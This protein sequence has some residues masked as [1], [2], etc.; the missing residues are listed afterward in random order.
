MGRR[1]SK[2][3]KRR[4]R[5]AGV[6]NLRQ[7]KAHESGP[8]AAVDAGRPGSCSPAWNSLDE[9]SLLD[10]AENVAAS[11]QP[12]STSAGDRDEVEVA[13]RLSYLNFSIVNSVPCALE[14]HNLD[15]CWPHAYAPGALT[16]GGA[17]QRGRSH[18]RSP[19]ATPLTDVE[20]MSEVSLTSTGYNQGEED[21]A[22][23]N[24]LAS[25]KR[26]SRRRPNK[27]TKKMRSSF[28][29]SSYH[30]CHFVRSNKESSS[31]LQDKSPAVKGS[32]E[33]SCKRHR[34][35]SK[36]ERFD[37]ISHGGYR[38]KGKGRGRGGG[39]GWENNNN[40]SESTTPVNHL[41]ASIALQC[42]VDMECDNGISFSTNAAAMTAEMEM[43]LG[44][45]AEVEKEEEEEEEEEEDSDHTP[46][47]ETES[48]ATRPCLD[49]ELYDNEDSELSESTSDRLG[50]ELPL[51]TNFVSC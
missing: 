6:G 28:Y 40:R 44:Q 5:A 30:L 13:K 3:K 51:Y 19:T 8:E 29:D 32:E 11:E 25:R 38:G 47:A 22:R 27:R 17:R 1:A 49:S 16:S 12:G 15:V 45:E 43:G 37:P 33:S 9:E 24:Q 39:G 2:R 21:I 23:K 26:A 41:P 31:S 42:L 50:A 7:G 4:A 46:I 10:Y 20:L 18:G 48:E 34:K 35:R 14:P 36:G